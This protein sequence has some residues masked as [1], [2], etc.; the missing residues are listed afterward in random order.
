MNDK[1]IHDT[2]NTE[3]DALPFMPEDA[4]RDAVARKMQHTSTTK[5]RFSQKAARIAAAAVLLLVV[6][7]ATLYATG[8]YAHILSYF[9]HFS[10]DARQSYQK[11]LSRYENELD[12]V[13]TFDG[14]TFQV[15]SLVVS[16][17]SI[18]FR[19][20]QE[21][22]DDS[23]GSRDFMGL[24]LSGSWQDGGSFTYSSP[25]GAFQTHSQGEYILVY[26]MNDDILADAASHSVTE[27]QGRSLSFT[28]TDS[29]DDSLACSKTIHT[30]IGEAYKEQGVYVNRTL[31]A[32]K[33]ASVYVEKISYNGMFWC[34]Y[35]HITSPRGSL[36]FV[37]DSGNGSQYVLAGLQGQKQL[38][39]YGVEALAQTAASQEQTCMLAVDAPETLT[40]I[41]L[42]LQKYRFKNTGTS[43]KPEIH[44]TSDGYSKETLDIDLTSGMNV[45]TYSMHAYQEYF[46]DSALSRYVI[47][48]LSAWK[49][50]RGTY[51]FPKNYEQDLTI[52]PGAADTMAKQQYSP[53]LLREIPTRDLFDLMMTSTTLYSASAYDT[54]MLALGTWRSYYNFFDEL[55]S[56][57]DA[58]EVVEDSFRDF[59]TRYR[60]ALSGHNALYTDHQKAA[61]ALYHYLLIQTGRAGAAGNMKHWRE[62]SYDFE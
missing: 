14:Q 51:H 31:S 42:C 37:D 59:D 33:T 16:N 32:D 24:G 11:N 39:T 54:A 48:D 18:I 13:L 61:E 25:T 57:E 20:C 38:I 2:F 12:A 36:D 15:N 8:A 4:F 34:V 44:A 9:R 60:S 43:Q 7:T 19:I 53:E 21:G 62:F 10:R 50:A 26:G 17:H 49:S 3:Y 45:R 5:A 28:F 27:L 22:S 40:D 55:M 23:H 52:I 56:R 29:A 58:L 46:E 30:V 47:S 41:T 1:S 35:Y 6:G